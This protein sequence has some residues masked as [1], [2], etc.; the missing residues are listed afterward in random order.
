MDLGVGATDTALVSGRR[1]RLLYSGNRRLYFTTQGL[2]G[3]AFVQSAHRLDSDG[4]VS[5]IKLGC[6]ELVFV[7]LKK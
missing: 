1:S 3:N 7:V 5:C 6:W 4:L 2:A